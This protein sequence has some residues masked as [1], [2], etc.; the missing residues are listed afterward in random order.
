LVQLFEFGFISLGLLGSL[1]VSYAIV[2]AE[3][4]ERPG[5]VFSLWAT[6]SLIMAGSAFWLMSQPMEMRGVVLGGG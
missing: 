3:R 6:V 5:R 1:L 4:I 2:A